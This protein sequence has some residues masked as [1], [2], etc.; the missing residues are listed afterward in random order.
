MPPFSAMDLLEVWEGG[1][2]L[3]SSQ[4]A[5]ALLSAYAGAP[6]QELA[7]LGIGERDARLA[8]VYEDLFG[9]SLQAYAECVTCGERLEYELPLAPLQ[10]SFDANKPPSELALDSGDLSLRLRL[11]N[12]LDL[13]AIENCSDCATARRRLAE[14]CV[15]RAERAQE[16]VAATD[17]PDEVIDA[18]SERLGQG[19]LHLE[20]L[21]DLACPACQGATRLTLAIDQALWAKIDAL[22]KSLLR[23]VHVLAQCYGWSEA[24]ILSLSAA[25]RRHYL[26]LALS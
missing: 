7:L 4:R 23:E 11:P 15:L 20:T 26:E 3:G 25:R 12:S 19:D 18:I 8:C 16:I 2:A 1:A 10:R 5:L 6:Q 14:R 13:L 24:E 17:L 22:C 21:I 9:L